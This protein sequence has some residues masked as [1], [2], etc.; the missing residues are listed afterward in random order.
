MDPQT[1]KVKK[2]VLHTN[3][4]GHSD[5]NSYMKCN[6]VICGPDC[7]YSHSSLVIDLQLCK[8]INCYFFSLSDDGSF[9]QDVNT[10]K[11]AITPSTK[12]EQVKVIPILNMLLFNLTSRFLVWMWRIME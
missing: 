6:F 10:S 9:H 11:C 7:K 2:F 1:H 8:Y 5:F 3:F 4:P 12:W